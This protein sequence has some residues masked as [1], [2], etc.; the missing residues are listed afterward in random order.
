MPRDFDASTGP[1]DV[2]VAVDAQAIEDLAAPSDAPGQTDIVDVAQ[3]LDAP[4]AL[5][6]AVA[7]DAPP[8]LDVLVAADAPRDAPDARADVV[9]VVLRD[10]P[11]D[12]VAPRDVPVTGGC[13][14][15]AA[16][17]YVARFRWTGSGS[18]SRATVSYEANTLPDRSRWR[19][20][21]YARASTSYSPVFG[22]PFLGEGGLEMGSN[23][24]MDV[25]L[26]TAG[27]GSIRGV[28]LAI[29]GRSYNT[30]ASGSFSWM[31]FDGSGAA[32]SGS[33]A[34]SAPYRWY[35]ADATSA[36]RAG[37]AG[38]LLR[39][40]P[41]PPSGTLVVSRVELCFNAS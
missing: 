7:A 10:A 28:T 36:F 41:G 13:L 15:G 33:V 39:I 32:P 1:D 17:A 16:G 24:F 2:A 30:T 25:E 12:M 8:A 23:V 11:P 20:G 14:S 38:A 35:R 31:T 34:N 4:P 29:Y 5:D 21:A 22:D 6:V 27:M 19:A 18:G 9:D 40:M 26:S 37:N 3:R